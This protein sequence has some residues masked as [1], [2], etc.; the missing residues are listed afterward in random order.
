MRSTQIFPA[1][2]K[3][4][5][6]VVAAV[7]SLIPIGSIALAQTE[8][9][10]EL[11]PLEVTGTRIKRTE[12]EGSSP[13]VV[14][15]RQYIEESG[16]T[17][18]NQLFKNV[19]YNTAGAIDESFT[20]EATPGSA[21]IDLRSLGINRTLV[22][23]DGRR[24][25]VSPFSKDGGSFVDINLIPLGA[26]ER[27]EILK[28]GASAIYGSDAIAG[29][30]NI[31]LK[32]DFEGAE[33]SVYGGG[34]DQGDGWEG[35]ITAIGGKTTDKGNVT[36]VL[37]LFDRNAVMAR[38]RDITKS[39]N[40]G[41]DDRSSAGDPGTIIRPD[42]GG[43]LLPDPR[44]PAS[45]LNPE[46]G[47]FCLYDFAVWNTLIPETQR[48]GLVASGDY[49]INPGL[50]AFFGANYTY[51]Q[52]DRDLAPPPPNDVFRIS[53]D[54]PNNPFPGEPILSIYR[55]TE[56]GARTDEVTTDA[57][58]LVGGLKGAIATWNWEL[59]VGGG[60]IDTQV[61]GTS[62]YATQ[63]AVQSAIDSGALNP[64]GPS[65]NFDPSSIRYEPQRD[66]ESNLFFTDLKA[67]G[68]ILQMQHGAL[69]AAVGAE[70]RSEDFS[71]QFDPI[72]ASGEVL[73]TGGTSGDGDRQ[74]AA[75]YAEFSIPA[76]KNLE[77]NLA[78]RYDNYSDFGGAFNPKLGL[79]WKPL[80]NLLVR[81][82][83]G[84]GFKAPSLPELYS[85]E[86]LLFA[87]VF[88]P[89][90]GRVR[91]NI[92]TIT[93]GNPDLDSEESRNFD[94]GLIW[95]I[96]NAWG[97][98]VDLWRIDVDNVVSNNPQYYVDNE[99]QFPDNVVR[100]SRGQIVEVRNPFRNIAKVDTSGV[101]FSTNYR[102]NTT[103]A[104][105]FGLSLVATYL[106]TYDEQQTPE[107]QSRDLAGKDGRPRWRGQA[108]LNWK[109]DDYQ[110]AFIVNYIGSYDRAT[111]TT[112]PYRVSSWT[113]VDTQFDWKLSS[114]KGG[115]LGFGINNLFDA[116]P[117]EELY[118]SE[119]WPWYNRALYS[120][121]GRF[122]YARYKYAF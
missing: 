38:D 59:G 65:P 84:T 112:E 36:F 87:N 13:L 121:R 2:K 10:L 55:P 40:R 66:G 5:C 73:G 29:V 45:S 108:I 111:E 1:G 79:R 57:W 16:A 106:D 81:G 88:D 15:D 118:W 119:G 67:T 76:A 62:G 52:S 70:Y 25:P 120:A 113:T 93:S 42:Q 90:T 107:A 34:T 12:I 72:T 17:T 58:N 24:V 77:I 95:D 35:Q 30:V 27:I 117:P 49:E 26:V 50:I 115:I 18:L 31:I 99:A 53:P 43:A 104:G 6:L 82:S 7:T 60:K 91:S 100:N 32:K 86:T 75:L 39:A 44:C 47:P 98:G 103:D 14:L 20:Q 28:D 78:G 101:D 23:L 80:D 96:N 41:Y 33:V 56:L 114:L 105:D 54:N 64:F 109:K 74:V 83:A 71:D 3:M 9:A 68:P 4:S 122:L 8:A 85:G 11:E 22:L 110:A 61:R 92:R 97:F 46:R 69:S 37:D 48:I 63:D 116:E 94:L 89:T 21:A 19:I 102:W 51:S